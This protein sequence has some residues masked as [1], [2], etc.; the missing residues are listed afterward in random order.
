MSD[1]KIHQLLI[2]TPEGISFSYALASPVTR[3]L[4]WIIDA[5]TIGMVSFSV[6]MLGS[7]LAIMSTDLAQAIFQIS[8]FVVPIGYGILLEWG[9]GGQTIG[10]RVMRLRVMDM[11]GLRLRFSQVFL[12]NLLR[13]IDS[14]PLLYLVGGTTSLV[15]RHAQRLGDLAAG[16]IVIRLPRI[17]SPDLTQLP[18][19]KFNSLLAYPHLTARLRQAVT[20]DEAALA[21]Q[22]LIL[23]DS[24]DLEARL[25]LYKALADFFREKIEFPQEAT[26]GVSDE[27]YLRNVLGV[28]F[29]TRSGK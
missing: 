13:A 10:K 19:G 11:Q 3:S 22:A 7:M 23:R 24:M 29:H 21:M 14:L 20:P 26:D 1:D 27:Q 2:R 16:T 18:E 4:A 25:E 6:T 12:R 5:A 9:W 28:V 17:S 15:S 8:F